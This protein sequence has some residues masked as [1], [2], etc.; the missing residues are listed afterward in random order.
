MRR[1]PNSLASIQFAALTFSNAFRL[2]GQ[3]A[4]IPILA[5]LLQPADYGVCGLVL[6]IIFALTILGEM[7]ATSAV[8]RQ[9]WS[10]RE[11]ENALFW[12]A[13]ALGGGLWLSISLA[14]PLI[15]LAL[16][17]VVPLGVILGLAPLPLLSALNIVPVARVQRTN[18]SW[19]FALGDMASVILSGAVAIYLAWH[20][21]GV[22]ALVAQQ[23]V[24]WITKGVILYGLSGYRPGLR[25]A[26]AKLG[27]MLA[28]GWP[29]SAANLLDFFARYIDNLLVGRALGTASLGAYAMAYQLMRIPDAVIAGPVAFTI[30]P[31]VDRMGGDR[32]RIEAT[33]L[34]MVETLLALAAPILLAASP[35]ADLLVALFLGPRWS[36]TGVLL[37]ILAPAG[38]TQ[39][40]VPVCYA[41]LMGT[42]K[43]GAQ[44]RATLISA[45]L[46][47]I[48]VTLGIAG[49]KGA[50]GVAVGVLIATWLGSGLTLW[51]AGRSIG[52]PF[53]RI[54]RVAINPIASGLAMAGAIAL[55]R[56]ALT[57]TPLLAQL[58]AGAAVA[59]LS[60]ALCA[61]PWAPALIGKLSDFRAGRRAAPPAPAATPNWELPGG[62]AD[63]A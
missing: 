52:V 55:A 37:A 36:D 14:A 27:A 22:Y 3:L 1:L 61:L 51:R 33:F 34:L 12:L 60:Y 25:V 16:G 5:R 10:A 30:F 50:H 21:W 39:C 57:G 8:V 59:A 20:G 43:T 54:A 19:I 2:I 23:L 53:A 49:G 48:G 32:A 24:I 29:L 40:L 38:V 31:A 6:P 42:G 18:R 7:G 9:E 47:V 11:N 58:L 13:I 28:F 41:I 17:N 63:F 15:R 56:M 26:G 46:V 4:I 62:E 44:L 45:G 35:L